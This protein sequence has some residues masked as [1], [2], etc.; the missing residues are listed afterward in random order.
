[1]ADLTASK[2]YTDSVGSIG[3]SGNDVVIAAGTF[4]YWATVQNT[5]AT[6]TLTL[7]FA[8]PAVAG[9]LILQPGQSITMNPGPLNALYGLGSGAATTCAIMGA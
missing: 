6:Q 7:S 8:K 5:H 1:M 9:R 2:P 3:T 4:S